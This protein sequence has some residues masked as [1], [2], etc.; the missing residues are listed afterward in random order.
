MTTASPTVITGTLGS[1]TFQP[2]CL[3]QLSNKVLKLSRRHLGKSARESRPATTS[4]FS[5]NE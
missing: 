5:M 1:P 4:T 3:E 2:A